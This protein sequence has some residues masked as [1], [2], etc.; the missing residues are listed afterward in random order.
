MRQLMKT[1]SFAR[2]SEE[3]N[4]I[5]NVALCSVANIESVENN[6]DPNMTEISEIELVLTY[7]AISHVRFVNLRKAGCTKKLD[8]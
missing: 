2:S 3:Y 1:L 8:T 5:T 7:E 4:R 6:I